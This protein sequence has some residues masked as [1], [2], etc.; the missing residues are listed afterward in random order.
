MGDFISFSIVCVRSPM[1][2]RGAR[3]GNRVPQ[4]SLTLKDAA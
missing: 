2:E 4:P 1:M 3:F